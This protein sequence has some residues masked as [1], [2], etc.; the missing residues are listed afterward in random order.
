MRNSTRPRRGCLAVAPVLTF[1]TALAH[2]SFAIA[3]LA[4]QPIAENTSAVASSLAAEVTAP[5]LNV[6]GATLT[7]AN[8]A[9]AG[10]F[11]G[12]SGTPGFELERGLVLSSGRVA[13]VLGPN[14]DPL[15]SNAWAGA[16]DADLDALLGFDPEEGSVD[17]ASLQ[18][19]FAC[20]GNAGAVRIRYSFATEEFDEL[21]ATDAMAIFVDGSNVATLPGTLQPVTAESVALE[22][23]AFRDNNLC[24]LDPETPCPFNLEADGFTNELTAVA[25]LLPGTATHT[26]KIV[27]ADHFFSDVDSWA[28]VEEVACVTA[29]GGVPVNAPGLGGVGLLGLGVGLVI[30][31][32]VTRIR[33]TPVLALSA[34][35]L[36]A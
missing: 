5:G 18:F 33:Q 29:Q 34:A 31:A 2:T 20:P 10:V 27:V 15:T 24:H 7:L 13:S 35:R 23:P 14:I 9:A 3:Q 1:L 28:F 22:L 11:T 16:G 19:Q 36:R 4:I 21:D 6:S 25:Q 8:V 12:G 17:A 32:S 30:L 26:L